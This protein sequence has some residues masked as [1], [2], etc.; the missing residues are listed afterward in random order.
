M[1]IKALILKKEK[2]QPTNQKTKQTQKRNKHI[3][4]VLFPELHQFMAYFSII[5]DLGEVLMGDKHCKPPLR[6]I[7]LAALH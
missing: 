1:S 4:I 5:K 3:G 2:T 6:S 7:I